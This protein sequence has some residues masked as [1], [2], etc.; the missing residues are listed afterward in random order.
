MPTENQTLYL[1]QNNFR[2]TIYL[3]TSVWADQLWVEIAQ[4]LLFI[5]ALK[6][7]FCKL[8]FDPPGS[9][10]YIYVRRFLVSF[11]YLI[12]SLKLIVC[13]ND[14]FI[15]ALSAMLLFVQEIETILKSHACTVSLMIVMMLSCL[16]NQFLV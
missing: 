1:D 7:H 3:S 15:F 14:F 5:F 2:T 10:D 16:L 13:N 9:G 11:A 8:I 12:E 4:R 6:L